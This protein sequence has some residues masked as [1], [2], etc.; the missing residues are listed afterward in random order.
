MSIINQ[1]RRSF[2]RD[3]IYGASSAAGPLSD[4][5]QAIL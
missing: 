3:V 4:W 5:V 1:N 2:E